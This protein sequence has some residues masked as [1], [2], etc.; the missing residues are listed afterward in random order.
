MDFEF[1]EFFESLAFFLNFFFFFFFSLSSASFQDKG[2][3][4]IYNFKRIQVVPNAKDFTDI[5]LSLT[6]RKTPTIIHPKI[7]ISRIRAFY[8]RKV[9]FT[10]KT[11]HERLSKIID[12]FPRLEVWRY[13]RR[14]LYL[15]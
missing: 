2:E 10:Q 6:Q 5:V 7:A 1:F 8:A 4:V 11:I 9:K 3:M 15:L 14:K 13:K 12:D